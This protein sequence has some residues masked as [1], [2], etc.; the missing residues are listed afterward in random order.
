MD[1]PILATQEHDLQLKYAS[2]LTFVNKVPFYLISFQI[3]YL[4]PIHPEINNSKRL[5]LTANLVPVATHCIYLLPTW[6][7]LCDANVPQG[8]SKLCNPYP[9]RK[10]NTKKMWYRYTCRLSPLTY[11]FIHLTGKK[12]LSSSSWGTSLAAR[13]RIWNWP[14]IRSQNQ[15]MKDSLIVLH[16]VHNSVLTVHKQFSGCCSKCL[17]PIV[18]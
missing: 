5:I 10:I 14:K 13:A 2:E 16:R 9:R 17:Q 15:A 12:C 3:S 6:F 1:S 4:F 11:F 7:I 8:L 18:P